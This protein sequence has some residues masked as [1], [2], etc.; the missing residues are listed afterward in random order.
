MQVARADQRARRRW[1]RSFAFG[2]VFLASVAGSGCAAIVG[3]EDIGTASG[4]D[5]GA[6]DASGE[7]GEA[8]AACNDA[9]ANVVPTGWTM[10]VYSTT[11]S[12]C[13]STLDSATFLSMDPTVDVGACTCTA[14][15][16]SPP[17][18][19]HGTVMTKQATVTGCASAS[20]MIPLD[21][22]CDAVG[23]GPVPA[24]IAVTPLAAAG[25]SCTSAVMMDAG[26]VQATR[27]LVCTSVACDASLCA[28]IV[29]V[30]FA[31][32]IRHDG[33]LDCPAGSAFATKHRVGDTPSLQCSA[34]PACTA[35]ATCGAATLGFYSG[36]DCSQGN[37]VA[38]V[39]ADGQCNA[40]N[41]GGTNYNRLV[42]TSQPSAVMYDAGTSTASVTLA[43]RATLCCR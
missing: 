39:S 26:A 17:S 6:V 37:Q 9:C 30:G 16:V 27:A 28:G 42:Y 12:S 4:Q 23:M 29:P 1:R 3:I 40:S 32:C 22:S 25:G 31:L 19:D 13:P 35:S 38:V 10:A 14:T 20:S 43:D 8:Q 24:Y 5:G 2:V 33:D 11:E 21:G 15:S 36:A 34:C 18:C 7:L 41:H